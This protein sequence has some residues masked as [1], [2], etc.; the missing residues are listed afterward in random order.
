MA[1]DLALFSH[2]YPGQDECNLVTALKEVILQLSKGDTMFDLLCKCLN[3]GTK[4][5]WDKWSKGLI[6]AGEFEEDLMERSGI[7]AGPWK[8]GEL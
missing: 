6:P 5:L 7:Y 3:R 1:L 8:I 4:S 2:V